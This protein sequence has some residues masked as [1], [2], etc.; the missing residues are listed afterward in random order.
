[1]TDFVVY[2]T[3]GGDLLPAAV[4]TRHREGDLTVE[5]FFHIDPAGKDLGGFQG[6]F[7]LRIGAQHI[8]SAAA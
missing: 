7:K 4:R 2:R 1:M 3:Q 8:V 5:P 6:E